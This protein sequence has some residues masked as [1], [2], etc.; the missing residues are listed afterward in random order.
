LQSAGYHIFSHYLTS[1]VIGGWSWLAD[2]TILTGIRIDSQE[3]FDVLLRSET[4][5]LPKIFKE[6][7]YTTLLAAPGTVHGEWEEGK[8]F[9]R[10]GE[11]MLG[12]DYGY[13][14]PTFSFVPIPDQYAIYKV[15]K[16]VL[17]KTESAPFFIRYTLVSS[18]G[19]FNRI[20]AYIEI[21]DDLGDGTIYYNVTNLC[22][23][24]DWFG[25]REYD[26]GYVAAIRYVVTVITEYLLKFIDDETLVI[27]VGDHQPKFPI[28]QRG[29]PLSVPVHVISRDREL[30]KPLLKYGY[31]PGFIP[32]QYPPH[33][34]METFL[35][36]FLE[37]IDGRVIDEMNSKNQ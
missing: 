16:K 26:V 7:G 22:F 19:P 21:W 2:A 29:S 3:K 18:H 36:L 9:Y 1:P 33:P 13:K 11:D 23:D 5:S 32:E 15:H 17:S 8:R 10:Y 34:G 31:T 30:I 27:L 37:I 25:G 12:S 4:E 20:P 35:T 14:G 28:T 6:A 24:N